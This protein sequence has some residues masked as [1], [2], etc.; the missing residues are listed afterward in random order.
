MSNDTPAE[1]QI[2]LSSFTRQQAEN[3]LRQRIAQ[4]PFL[5]GAILN[6]IFELDIG[7]YFVFSVLPK[8]GLAGEVIYVV[9]PEDILSS[10]R[11]QDFDTLMSRL[12]V[13][14]KKDAIEPLA[15]ARLFLRMVARRHGDVL[16]SIE[17]ESMLRPGQ[18][19]PERF[20]APKSWFDDDGAHFT[21]WVYDTDS[22]KP[23]LWEV[24][25]AADGKTT[26]SEDK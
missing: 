8:T 18:L 21:F 14:W 9:G 26:S 16:E 23:S 6:P 7:G 19:S 12:G 13:G 10:G 2:E 20:F 24:H 11:I 25:V 15:F 22:M 5:Q 3:R 4:T 1:S 17:G